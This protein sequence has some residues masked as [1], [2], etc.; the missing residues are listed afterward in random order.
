MKTCSRGLLADTHTH[1]ISCIQIFLHPI[2]TNRSNNLGI[3]LATGPCLMIVQRQS[4]NIMLNT[5]LNYFWS[6]WTRN[7]VHLLVQN[8][9]TQRGSINNSCKS[10]HQRT[11][12]SDEC[13]LANEKKTT[14]NRNLDTF[15]FFFHLS[16]FVTLDAL[17]F[18]I[19]V[20]CNYSLLYT[21]ATWGE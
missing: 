9:T 18:C 1:N 8:L 10:C 20:G 3:V 2:T 11:V 21:T 6:S 4:M 13:S 12:S 19:P 15:S 14:V 5:R 17:M 16:L 7:S